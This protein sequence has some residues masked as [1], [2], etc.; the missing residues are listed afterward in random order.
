MW[1][2]WVKTFIDLS[3][4]KATL[5]VEMKRR[6]A[7]GPDVV[8]TFNSLSP[9]LTLKNCLNTFSTP[10]TWRMR[11]PKLNFLLTVSDMFIRPQ[12]KPIQLLYWTQLKGEENQLYSRN[13]SF[14]WK[15]GMMFIRVPYQYH[16]YLSW[17]HV[18]VLQ[19]YSP[20]SW[21]PCER[22]PVFLPSLFATEYT[23]PET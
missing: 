14:R 7:R 4:Q 3:L 6:P 22:L 16:Q 10:P 11:A 18:S 2:F 9:S 20:C 15:L 5:S 1:P 12:A 21:T 19:G 23:L 8:E 17:K 13:Q